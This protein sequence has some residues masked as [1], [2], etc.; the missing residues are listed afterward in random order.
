VDLRRTARSYGEANIDEFSGELENFLS[1]LRGAGG[2]RSDFD[3]KIMALA[4]RAAIDAVARRLAQ[5]PA[6]DVDGYTKAIA[7]IFDLATRI[8]P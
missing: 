3:P 1:R 6:L 7:N 8:Q 2:L 4:I 5:D